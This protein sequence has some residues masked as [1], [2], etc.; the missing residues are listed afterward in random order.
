MLRGLLLVLLLANLAFFVWSQGGFGAASG[1][2]AGSEHEPERLARQVHP[3][4]VQ[5]LTPPVAASAQAPAPQA[6]AASAAASSA[7]AADAASAPSAPASEAASS[8][9]LAEASASAATPASAASVASAASASVAVAAVPVPPPPAPP[10][11]RC[12]EAGPFSGAELATAETALAATAK[13]RRIARRW[14]PITPEAA[15]A[16]TAPQHR[17][18]I[19]AT[20]DEVAVLESLPAS[21]VGRSFTPCTAR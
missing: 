17:L 10:G 6:S 14:V 18:R 8:P 2:A 16:P 5:L 3:E 15:S 21:V 7:S 1:A 13:T 9:A 19:D 4:A 12:L 20:P 11:T